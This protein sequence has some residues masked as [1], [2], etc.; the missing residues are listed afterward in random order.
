MKGRLLF[1]EDRSIVVQWFRG[2]LPAALL[3]D[4]RKEAALGM[5]FS[6]LRRDERENRAF[7]GV[8]AT[9]VVAVARLDRRRGGTT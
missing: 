2:A 9:E 1:L 6:T 8:V 4:G 7:S 5:L 3:I